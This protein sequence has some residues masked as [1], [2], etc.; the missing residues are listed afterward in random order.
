MLKM[1]W[2]IA[3]I[4]FSNVFY[5]I[6][7]KSTPDTLSPFASLTVTYLIGAAVSAALFFLFER[8]SSLLAEYRKLNWTTFVLGLAIVGLETGNICMYKAG[9]NI[10]S[11]QLVQSSI[12]AICL[13]VVGAVIYRERVT[14]TKLVGIAVCMAGLYLINRGS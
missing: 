5:H 13:I 8:G 4:V 3:L 12:L 10:S 1:L 7:S 2:P 9:W 14:P 6:C 11:G